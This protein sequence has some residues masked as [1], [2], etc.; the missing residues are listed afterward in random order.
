[1]NTEH[2][3]IR[4]RFKIENVN[5]HLVTNTMN[6]SLKMEHLKNGV[7]FTI[8]YNGTISIRSPV[9]MFEYNYKLAESIARFYNTTI[10][11]RKCTRYISNI[12]NLYG[13][14]IMQS[15]CQT[16]CDMIKTKM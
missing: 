11:S 5:P 8:Y 3:I 16:S 12:T 6:N 10:I 14:N 9:N 4:Y 13:N 1:M 7:I 15:S 2:I